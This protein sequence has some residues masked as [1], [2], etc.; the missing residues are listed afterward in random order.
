[1]KF[2][3]VNKDNKLNKKLVQSKTVNHFSNKND[4]RLIAE[5]AKKQKVALEE[6]LRDANI[7]K[8]FDEFLN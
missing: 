4:I 3:K 7:V 8:S 6:A 5:N 2:T 1:M